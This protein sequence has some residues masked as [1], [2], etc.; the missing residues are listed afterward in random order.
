ML[1]G[2]AKK[3]YQAEYMRKHRKPASQDKPQSTNDVRPD[4]RPISLPDYLMVDIVR[5]NQRCEG[6]DKD[7][8]KQRIAIALDYAK[9]HPDNNKALNTDKTI[10]TDAAGKQHNWPTGLD[11]VNTTSRPRVI[12]NG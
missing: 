5:I 6:G 8:L 11:T 10:L 4:V 7:K 12:V 2:E 9:Q 3:Q 1:T